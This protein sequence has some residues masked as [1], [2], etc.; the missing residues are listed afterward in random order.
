[1]IAA[2]A[3]TDHDKRLARTLLAT[4][5]VR[6]QLL[7]A[8]PELETDDYPDLRERAVWFAIRN[9]EAKQAPIGVEEIEAHLAEQDVERGTVLRLLAGRE[10]LTELIPTASGA[11]DTAAS[12]LVR[13]W[14]D[15]LRRRRENQ[16]VEVEA[17]EQRIRGEHEIDN[18]AL[19][20]A[21]VPIVAGVP[22]APDR[23]PALVASLLIDVARRPP[24]PLRSY[25]TGMADL[26]AMLGGGLTTR[27]LVSVCGPPGAGKSAF[28]V[29]A[30]IYQA[31]RGLPVLYVCT[32][33]EEQELMSRHAANIIDRPWSAIAR[34]HVPMEWVYE[35]LARV[36]VYVIGSEEVPR[37]AEDAMA[38]IER[39]ARKIGELHTTPPLVIVDYMQDMARGTDREMR[40]RVGDIA[41]DL[42]AMAQRLDCAM[43]AISSVARAYY[44]D[45]RAEEMRKLDDPTVYLAAAKESGDVDY[46][47]AAV[48]F[49]DVAKDEAAQTRPAR[50]AVPKSRHGHT[51]FAGARFA[52]PSGRWVS[53]LDAVSV[54]SSPGRTERSSNTKLDDAD[55]AVLRTVTTMHTSGQGA[56]CTR[57]HLAQSCGIGKPRVPV[58]LDRL[59]HLGRIRVA[60][61]ERQEADG[62]TK[63]RSVYELVPAPGTSPRPGPEPQPEPQPELDLEVVRAGLHGAD[64]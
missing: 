21:D 58:A 3:H 52:G 55:Q 23:P 5:V 14:A 2:T 48:L 16:A 33:L 39:E 30:A 57:S 35:A 46:A 10:Y 25:P 40:G 13:G 9:L 43:M 49:L 45:R 28:A 22:A 34:G 63:R 31:A 32:E 53:A 38:L 61:V 8:V 29:S 17:E 12:A 41:T 47:S 26:D 1:V 24:R 50:I 60:V 54:M 6:P 64:S 11:D 19:S 4:I 18:I 56:L 42:R 7:A 37:K 44:S 36:S 27:Q 15:T 59:V 51:G 62:R 20:D